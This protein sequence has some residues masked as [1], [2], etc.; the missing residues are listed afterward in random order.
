MQKFLVLAVWFVWSV[1]AFF[2]VLPPQ[3]QVVKALAEVKGD[4]Y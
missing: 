1:G 3:A 2:G 4:D